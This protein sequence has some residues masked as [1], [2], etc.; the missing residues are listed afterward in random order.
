MMGQSSVSW[1]NGALSS[2]FR[3]DV[4]CLDHLGPFHEFDLDVLGEFLRG[5]RDRFEAKHSKPLPDVGQRHD[6]DDLVMKESYDLFWSSGRYDE[7]L[8]VVARD[9]RITELRRGGQIR[10]GL[11]AR[12][13]RH[14]EAAHLPSITC[15]AAG[16]GEAKHICVC[17]PTAEP[18]ARPALLK[19][20]CTRS[21]PRERRNV[22]PTRCPGV[23]VPGDA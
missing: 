1:A 7:T 10:Q 3:L 23:P 4:G 13:A 20:T 19:G 21:R 2:S 17:P 6:L 14:R 18:T 8:P 15:C 11:R 16:D 9:I 22:S 5:A 12:L